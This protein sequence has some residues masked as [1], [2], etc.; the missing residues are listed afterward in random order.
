MPRNRPKRNPMN[1]LRGNEAGTKKRRTAVIVLCVVLVALFAGFFAYVETYYRADAQAKAALASDDAVQ[2]TQTEYGWFFDGPSDAY[3]MVFYPGGKVE[4]EAY[5]PL[6]HQLAHEG[7]DCYLVA[8]PLRLAF[9]GTDKAAPIIE[10]H[11]YPHWYVGG[12]SLGGVFASAFASEH[13]DTL[14]GIILF[15]AYPYKPLDQGL[16]E[17]SLYGSEDT[18]LNQKSYEEAKQY[19]P[20]YTFEHVIEGGNHAQ[21]GDYGVQS[22]DGVARISAE[23]QRSEAVRVIME[24]VT[25]E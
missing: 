20:A 11:A 7:M 3:A 1:T 25:Q 23:E 4:A 17:I 15:A 22:G 13:A 10:Q 5:A 16:T 21:F 18:V 9:F 8:M 12:H 14:D 6:L 2:V 19:A 24:T